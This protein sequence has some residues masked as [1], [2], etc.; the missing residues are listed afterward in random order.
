MACGGC[1]SD[2][3]YTLQMTNRIEHNDETYSL[4]FTALEPVAWTA[5][6]S[7]KLYVPIDGELVGKKMSFVTLPSEPTIRFTTRIRET[8]S[9]YKSA[10]NALK[11]GDLIE[12]SEPSGGFGL[13]RGDRPALLLS[14]GV[15]LA[16][17][18]T[19]IKDYEH[20]QEGIWRL[21]QINADR[22]DYLY[23]EE[24]NAISVSTPSF[25]SYY[26][27][28]REDFY[29]QVD[30]ECQNLMLATGYV[31]YVYVV[32][33]EGFVGDVYEY[34]IGVGFD[35]EDMITDGPAPQEASSGGCGGCSGS[36]GGCGCS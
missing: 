14:N 5:G 1:G 27:H 36:C 10:L 18:R 24:L 3:T 15:G 34:L 33:S 30:F 11:T 2:R 28:H 7:S 13:K 9:D 19:L 31:P 22:G 35:P 23:E 6:A 17:M 8:C 4:D 21:A 12:I 20:N 32:G 16:A 29:R 26:V 25:K